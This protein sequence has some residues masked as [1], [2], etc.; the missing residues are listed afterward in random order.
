MVGIIHTTNAFLPLLKATAKEHTARVIT[1]STGIADLDFTFAAKLPFSAPYSITKA[2]TNMVVAKY[3]V[4]FRDE[5]IVFL[6]ISPGFVNT[7]T[8]PRKLPLRSSV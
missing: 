1:L 8:R 2:A 3:A 5:N 4:R 7:S 6:G